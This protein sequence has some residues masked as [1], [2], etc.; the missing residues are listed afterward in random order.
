MPPFYTRLGEECSRVK[1]PILSKDIRILNGEITE[2]RMEILNPSKPVDT[3]LPPKYPMTD[4]PPPDTV[5]NSKSEEV[6][7]AQQPTRTGD[8]TP[9]NQNTSTSSEESSENQAVT[10]GESS[11]QQPE[12]NTV[13]QETRVMESNSDDKSDRQP[14]EVGE[15]VLDQQ[16]HQETKS[17]TLPET[18]VS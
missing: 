18:Q 8:D 4:S 14:T 15:S 3:V 13:A 6:T 2:R 17:G 1:G 16:Q 7:N 12:H 9:T 10:S 5:S 11:C